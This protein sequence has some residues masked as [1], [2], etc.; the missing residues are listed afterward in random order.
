MTSQRIL[1]ACWLWAHRM[2]AQTLNIPRL[3]HGGSLEFWARAFRTHSPMGPSRCHLSV[4]SLVKFQS[5][6]L[7]AQESR[8]QRIQQTSMRN[9]LF[10]TNKKAPHFKLSNSLVQGPIHMGSQVP[11]L[12]KPLIWLTFIKSGSWLFYAKIIGTCVKSWV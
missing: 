6:S 3:I 7:K 2:R 10:S 5:H 4:E 9:R 11:I 12:K 1:I 8:E